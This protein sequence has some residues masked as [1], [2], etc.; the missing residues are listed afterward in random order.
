ME[1]LS[2][3]DL[4]QRYGDGNTIDDWSKVSHED[5]YSFLSGNRSGLKELLD[6]GTLKYQPFAI[7]TV[8][9]CEQDLEWLAGYFLWETNPESEGGSR[10]ITDNKI[11]RENHT[12]FFNFFV[13]KDKTKSLAEQS[14][15][16]NRLILAPRGSMKSTIGAADI[17]QWVLNFP[18]IRL[19]IMT[20]ADDLAIGI[21]DEIKTH[22]LI[23]LYEPSLMNLFFPE[24]CLEEKDLTNQYEF[25][26]PVWLQKQVKRK[27]PTILATSITS[28]VSG[29]HFEVMHLDDAVSNRNCENEEQAAKIAKKFKINRKMLRPFG[30]CTKI[31]TRY[32]DSDM[33]G[34]E[35]DGTVGAI[36]VASG[37]GW[38]LTESKAN[39][40]LILVARAITIKPEVR[41]ALANKGVPIHLMYEEATEEGCILLMP[42][43]LSY[44]RLLVDYNNDRQGQT[45]EGTFE[46]QMNQNPLPEEEAVFD[47]PM[48]LRATVPY[49]ELPFQGLISHTWDFAFSAKKNRDFTTGSSVIWG[50]NA[51]A[52]VND[53]VRD[54]F[55]NPTDLA[56]AIVEM[57]VKHHPFVIGVE[58]AGAS[59]FI[60]PTVISEA[61]KTGDPFV[62]AVCGRIDWIPINRDK[63]AKKARMAALQPL[64]VDN[65]LKFVAHL[66]YLQTLY[67]EFL[68]CQGN[69][70]R[71]NDIPD[72]ISHQPRYAPRVLNQIAESGIVSW[73]W[74][75]E[76]KEAFRQRAAFNLIY[77]EGTD[78]FGQEGFGLDQYMSP[79]EPS[80]SEDYIPQ[81]AYQGLDN[82]LGTM[83]G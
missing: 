64:L 65:L 53:L 66:P 58:D 63:D 80:M 30:Y 26:C 52:Y 51:C 35:I 22:F 37:P 3:R 54:R 29:F 19:L 45:E 20:A 44:Q 39:S 61:Q 62:I 78:P 10:P 16:K 41:R 4:H 17:V 57:A 48:L 82:I 6:S 28:T 42:K 38:S 81:S 13:K 49:T 69:M 74:T 83:I 40:S 47:M 76:Q 23:K 2:L 34:S 24:F 68:R 55:A 1:T 7:E 31:G 33:Y 36:E 75:K 71:H 12:P 70:R 60:E 79:E 77:N 25:Q 8:R 15:V 72:V 18:A 32:L 46:G 59:R 50:A 67:D 11:C 43:V 14:V 21:L 5:L 27:E 56:K 73:T 9:R